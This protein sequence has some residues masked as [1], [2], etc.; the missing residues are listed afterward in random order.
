MIN[1]DLNDKQITLKI[2]ALQKFV[3]ENKVDKVNSIVDSIADYYL[4]NEL[5]SWDNSL[6]ISL[7][8]II[9]PKKASELIYEFNLKQTIKIIQWL[10]LKELANI[11]EEFYID[12]IVD[13]RTDIENNSF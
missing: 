4:A 8:E 7:F 6:V 2:K 10:S 5:K 3:I 13:I 12:E 1:N 9:T 11:F